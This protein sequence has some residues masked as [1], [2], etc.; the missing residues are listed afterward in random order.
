MAVEGPAKSG[1][2]RS[3]PLGLTGAPSPHGR[4]RPGL[5]ATTTFQAPVLAPA[6]SPDPLPASSSH[7]EG[8]AAHQQLWCQFPQRAPV[9]CTYE[10]P[11]LGGRTAP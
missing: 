5:G 9:Q 1:P 10:A 2:G 7:G 4:Q 3:L 8:P 11:T 6:P